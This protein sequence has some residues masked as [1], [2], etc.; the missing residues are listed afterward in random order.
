MLKMLKG[1]PLMRFMSKYGKISMREFAAGFKDPFLREVFPFVIEDLPGMSMMGVIFV[2]ANLHI[3]NNGWPIGGSLEFSKAIEKRY[4]D[5][6][7]EVEYNARV[8][9]ILVENDMAV[10]VRLVDG[11][12]HRADS[13]D[14]TT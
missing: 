6:G 3:K 7:G 13:S 2:L 8:E 10:G 1:I 11:S 5:L 9:K 14:Q 4:R 12:E